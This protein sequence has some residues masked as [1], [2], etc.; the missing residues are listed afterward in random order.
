MPAD[1]VRIS[2]EP[3]AVTLLVILTSFVPVRLSVPSSTCVAMVNAPAKL[4]VGVKVTVAS[5]ALRSAADPVALH[6]P[7]A[8]V[9]VTAPEVGVDRLPAPVSDRVRVT[10]NGSPSASPTTISVRSMAT[11]TAAASGAYRLE[12][13]GGESLVPTTSTL[14]TW[15]VVTVPSLTA[16]VKLSA[17]L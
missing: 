11:S 4:A 13:V 9:G 10:V 5:T 12:A 6:T 2:F 16:T 15:V 17:P 14:I 1:P 8:K 3:V 7:A